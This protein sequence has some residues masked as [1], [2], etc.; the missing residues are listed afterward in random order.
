MASTKQFSVPNSVLKNES[1]AT[2]NRSY[3]SFTLLGDRGPKSQSTAVLFD[4]K[5]TSLFYTQI[6]RD[7]IGCWSINKPFT[8]ENQGLV[9]TD[10]EALV[11]PSDLKMKDGQLYVLSNRLPLFFY[12]SLK[13]EF[14]YRIL[15]GKTEELIVGT[16]C[17]NATPA[18]TATMAPTAQPGAPPTQ[19]GAPPT[20]PG[21]QPTQPGA[22]PA[23][24][25]V[26]PTAPPGVITF[27][28]LA[29]PTL[30]T[31]SNSQLVFAPL[32]KT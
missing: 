23:Q 11:Y 19:P 5:T 22:P 18:V 27:A 17:S 1:F 15:F 4:D 2:S 28:P 20:Q 16:I 10:P 6:S 29:G 12:G 8:P 3:N 21:A 7:G 32:N 13:A 26:Q 31:N 25:G 14:N 30:V 24:P 9:D